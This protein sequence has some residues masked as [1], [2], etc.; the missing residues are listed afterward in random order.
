MT[1]G[2]RFLKKEFGSLNLGPMSLNQTQN[3]FF[4]HFLKFGTY[5]FLEI[6]CNDSLQLCLTSSR[7]KTY[8]NNFEGPNLGQTD[9]NR[10]RNLVFCHFLKFGPLVFL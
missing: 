10:A 4:C 8:E 7:G 9:Q 1:D 6:A 3:K 2:A 5:V